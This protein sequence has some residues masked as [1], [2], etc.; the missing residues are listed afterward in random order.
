MRETLKPYNM[1]IT[2]E[3]LMNETTGMNPVQFEAYCETNGIQTEWLEVCITDFN[4]GVY[5]VALSDYDDVNVFAIDGS[6]I[7]FQ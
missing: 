4:D 5:N 6:T 7:L 1:N 3:T 2:L